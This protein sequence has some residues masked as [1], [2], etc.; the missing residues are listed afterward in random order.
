[1]SGDPSDTGRG[2]PP[3]TEW[4]RE[5][6]AR[7]EAR[8]ARDRIQLARMRQQQA[9]WA[10]RVEA[11]SRE[12]AEL[13]AVILSGDVRPHEIDAKLLTGAKAQETLLLA[14]RIWDVIFQFRL[15]GLA[16]DALEFLGGVMRD[17]E[18][19]LK[20]RVDA[21]KT[22]LGARA[23]LANKINNPGE[24]AVRALL[25]GMGKAADTDLRKL[26][27]GELL[28][29]FKRLLVAATDTRG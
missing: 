11:E 8:E 19:S 12:Q 10:A 4:E 26:G 15:D 9:A 2:P 13:M 17:D 24:A 14:R 21:A 29:G 6:Q 7:D 5:K 23:K 27:D 18:A 16:H 1:M 28:E 22:L 25:G 20:Q 3:L